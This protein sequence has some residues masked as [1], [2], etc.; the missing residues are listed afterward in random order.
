M[1][2]RPGHVGELPHLETA[3][4]NPI[5]LEFEEEERGMRVY[6]AARWVNNTSQHG[7]AKAFTFQ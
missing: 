6:F 3:T 2:A 5:V 7:R 4:A 1:T